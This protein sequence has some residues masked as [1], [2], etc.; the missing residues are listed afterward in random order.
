M[1]LPFPGVIMIESYSAFAG[2]NALGILENNASLRIIAVHSESVY[3]RCGDGRLLLLCPDKYGT[4]PFGISVH[5]YGL[6]R[7]AHRFAEGEVIELSGGMLLLSDGSKLHFE[8]DRR[9]E[10]VRKAVCHIPGISAAE[11]CSEYIREHASARGMGPAL[12]AFLCIGTPLEVA[13]A[14]ALSAAGEADRFENALIEGDAAMLERIALR[15]IGLGCGLTPSGD[16]FLCG[17]LYAFSRYEGISCRA[18]EYLRQLSDAV[19]VN[20][21]NTNEVSA[22]YIRCALEGGYFEVVERVLDHISD[23]NYDLAELENALKRLLSVG[24]S[25]GSDILCG[26]LFAIYL[27]W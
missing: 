25:S 3:A 26:M 9:R 24:A 4:V 2:K 6:F 27:L 12:P 16:D 1:R 17:M 5:D 20:I 10:T 8:L 19:A 14:Y 7:A 23:D 15:F 18:H 22:E 13:N 11:Y 21:G